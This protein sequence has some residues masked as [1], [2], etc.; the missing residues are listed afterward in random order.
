MSAKN[1]EPPSNGSVTESL[2]PRGGGSTEMRESSIEYVG[3]KEPQVS[4]PIIL[5]SIAA[6]AGAIAAFLHFSRP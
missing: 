2:T 1:H 3:R 6:V 4:V 5:L